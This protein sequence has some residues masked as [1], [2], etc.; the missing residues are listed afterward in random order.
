MGGARIRS[1]YISNGL[2]D[3]THGRYTVRT[4]ARVNCRREACVRGDVYVRAA[5]GGGARASGFGLSY[6]PSY[7]GLAVAIDDDR[8]RALLLDT[9]DPIPRARSAGRIDPS[10]D[11]SIGIGISDPEPEA[12]Q[13]LQHK[14]LPPSV[15]TVGVG[16]TAMAGLLAA[17]GRRGWGCSVLDRSAGHS[18]SSWQQLPVPARGSITACVPR[19]NATVT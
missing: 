17:T 5:R 7:W 14:L 1:S 16:G 12:M 11:R 10:M 4:V 18:S 15:R 19:S 3:R 13:A 8:P 2:I 9:S 6:R